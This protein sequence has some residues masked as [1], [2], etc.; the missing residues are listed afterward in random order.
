MKK[1]EICTKLYIVPSRED[2]L[3]RYCEKYTERIERCYQLEWDTYCEVCRAFI[4]GRFTNDLIP[5]MIDDIEP[6]PRDL[7]TRFSRFEKSEYCQYL[8]RNAVCMDSEDQVIGKIIEYE[9][10]VSFKIYIKRER[11]DRL[12]NQGMPKTF[13]IKDFN[14]IRDVCVKSISSKLKQVDF[15]CRPIDEGVL[16]DFKFFTINLIQRRRYNKSEDLLIKGK[17]DREMNVLKN[18]KPNKM[19]FRKQS[20]FTEFGNFSEESAKRS[21]EAFGTIG[22]VILGSVICGTL[23]GIDFKRK[24]YSDQLEELKRSTKYYTSEEVDKMDEYIFK[25]AKDINRVEEKYIDYV[26]TRKSDIETKT[27]ITDNIRQTSMDKIFQSIFKNRV[28][29]NNNLLIAMNFNVS[30]HDDNSDATFVSGSM[31][32]STEELD[33][34][35]KFANEKVA[36][37]NLKYSKS[38][39]VGIYDDGDYITGAINTYS[40]IIEIEPPKEI[41]EMIIEIRNRY[42]SA[43]NITQ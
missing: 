3:E 33:K 28:N 31:G 13:C 27:Y 5:L 38:K 30:N 40:R 14:S 17:R 37:V 7:S 25:L 43:N 35:I 24:K 32:S 9:L 26:K 6:V 15:D 39:I 23:L 22:L 8:F 2:F 34:A 36:N 4:K 10:P 16:N 21:Q 11:W 1:K 19:F 29:E 12:A 41:K 20:L 42:A 18:Y